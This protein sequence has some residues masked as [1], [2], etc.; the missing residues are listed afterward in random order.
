MKR[1]ELKEMVK[2]ALVEAKNPF[3]KSIDDIYTK[4]EGLH[5]DLAHEFNDGDGSLLNMT[6]GKII[7]KQIDD[8]LSILDRMTRSLSKV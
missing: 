4:V 1:S 8:V 6:N 5:Y 3:V 2:Q 7:K